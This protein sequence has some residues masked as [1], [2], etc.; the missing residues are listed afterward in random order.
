M[1]SVITNAAELTVL[2]PIDNTY[3]TGGG[4]VSVGGCVILA[5]K[6]RPFTVHEIF[7]V[8]T[9]QEDTFGSPTLTTTRMRDR[10]TASKCA[11]SKPARKSMRNAEKSFRA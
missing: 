10:T 6:G 7:G 1:K 2:E 8:G 9:S 3:K 5:A 11:A 4:P